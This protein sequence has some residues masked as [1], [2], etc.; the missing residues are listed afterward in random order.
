[1]K[2]TYIQDISKHEG[3]DV[4]LKGW[5]QNKRSSGKI[6]FLIIRDGSGTIQGV[7]SAAAVG[8][9]VFQQFDRLTQESAVVVRGKVRADKRAPSGF[10]M[11]VTG[12]DI[13]SIA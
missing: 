6:Q 13:V 3:Q 9:E 5:I 8:P 1:M 10:E 2:Q 11:D 4:T 7:V 12:Y